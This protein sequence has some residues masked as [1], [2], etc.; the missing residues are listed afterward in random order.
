MHLATHGEF[1]G[2]RPEDAYIQFWD[3]KLRLDQLRQLPLN[4]PTAVE[5]MVLS[6]CRTALGDEEAELG[7][8]GLAA[9]AG[10]KTAIG[11]LWYVSDQGTLSLMSEFYQQLQTAPIKAEALRQ[12]QLAMLRGEIRLE[13][14]RIITSRSGLEI[15]LP[16]A[17]GDVQG[18]EFDH[19]FY[20]AAF[21]AI[22]SPW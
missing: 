9:Q 15:P 21:T 5:L 4:E 22:G 2:D 12:A 13:D 14:G 1:T 18:L 19:P 17:I 16:E 10:V 7:F 6:A 8:A 20:W 11:S 3:E